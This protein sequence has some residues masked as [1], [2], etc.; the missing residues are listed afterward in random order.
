MVGDTRPDL[1]GLTSQT[2]CRPIATQLAALFKDE[3]CLLK[4]ASQ[5]ESDGC[6]RVKYF[7]VGRMER[8]LRDIGNACSAGYERENMRTRVREEC[9]CI[10]K[11]VDRVPND[12]EQA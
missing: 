1:Y 11:Q 6:H 3:P 5:K 2:L 10:R 4:A 8:E 9:T 12:H 7:R